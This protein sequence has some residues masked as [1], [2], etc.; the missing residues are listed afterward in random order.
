[1][2]WVKV[3]DRMHS[4]RK[5]RALLRAGGGKKRDAAP[6]GLWQIGRAHV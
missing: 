3:D 2:A 5:T 6:M 1:M 4:H